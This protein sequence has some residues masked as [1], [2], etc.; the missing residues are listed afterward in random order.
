MVECTWIGFVGYVFAFLFFFFG[1]ILAII[2][3]LSHL[4]FGYKK[5]FFIKYGK[6]KIENPVT[7]IIF[8]GFMMAVSIFMVNKLLPVVVKYWE[9]LL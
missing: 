4:I 3:T 8:F 7:N 5:G 2:D 6:N 9:C 1:S